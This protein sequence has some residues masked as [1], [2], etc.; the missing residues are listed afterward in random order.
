MNDNNVDVVSLTYGSPR[1]QIWTFASAIDEYPC[2]HLYNH[3]CPCT[4]TTK[5]RTIYITSF[6]GNDY[7]CETGVP[8]GQIQSFSVGHRTF[9]AD[10][11]L[12]WSRL[13][14]N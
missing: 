4:N 9:H 13:W 8:P 1:Q 2:P 11:P 12:W 7:F 14:S 3:K 5:K 6:I 10:D